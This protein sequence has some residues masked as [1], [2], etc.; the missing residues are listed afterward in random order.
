MTFADSLHWKK[1]VL[2]GERN[3]LLNLKSL[4]VVTAK[5]QLWELR[6]PMVLSMPSK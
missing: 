2:T 6:V 1:L 3:C 4:S 5:G